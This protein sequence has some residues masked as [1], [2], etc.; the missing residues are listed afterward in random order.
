MECIVA[1]IL[2][3]TLQSKLQ[4]NLKTGEIECD[5]TFVGG[6]N[7][8]RH[9]D[10]KVHNSQGRSFKDKIP[11]QGML[12]RN[13]KLNAFVVANT[14][15]SSL[16]PNLLKYVGLNSTIYSDEWHGYKDLG[17]HFKE[18]YFIEHCEDNKRD[19]E[20]TRK[21]FKNIYEAIGLLMD[22][23]KPTKVGFIT[24]NNKQ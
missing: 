2:V 3:S 24:D 4:P 8:N 7:K 18:H 9:Y 5:E 20:E 19:N 13:G 21:H 16:V 11:V 23:T 1:R 22:R 14:Q 10:K 12:Q 17:E 15:A 6:L